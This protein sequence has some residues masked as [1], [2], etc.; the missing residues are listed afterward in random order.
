MKTR[1]LLNRDAGG[2]FKFAHR[3]IMEYMVA[4]RILRGD[5]HLDGVM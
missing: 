2:N 5:K 4:E 1:S 3:S